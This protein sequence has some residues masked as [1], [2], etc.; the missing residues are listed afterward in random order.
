MKNVFKYLLVLGIF[1]GGLGVLA[2]RLDVG[3]DTPRAQSKGC[4]LAIQG[5]KDIDP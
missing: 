3:K 4:C 2:D 1:L 5:D